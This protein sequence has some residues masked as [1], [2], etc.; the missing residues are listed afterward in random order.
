MNYVGVTHRKCTI[1]QSNSLRN[2][3]GETCVH[4]GVIIGNEILLERLVS[5]GADVDAREAK[6]GKTALHI[7]VEIQKLHVNM[8]Q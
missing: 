1:H 5:T 3:E 8:A 7:V 6:S 4:L 2:Y